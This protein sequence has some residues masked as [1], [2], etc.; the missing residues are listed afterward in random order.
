MSE[1]IAVIALLA[2]SACTSDPMPVD[3]G[4]D[5]GPALD[6]DAGGC[7]AGN[8]PCATGDTCCGDLV[9]RGNA[10]RT[11]CVAANDTCFVGPDPGCCFDPAD[12]GSGE[13][14]H[15][16]EC[17]GMGEGVCKADPPAGS[18]WSAIDC[19][20]GGPCVGAQVCGCGESCLVPDV[21]GTC[22]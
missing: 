17:R 22:M 13:R 21:L 12:C 7:V 5:G 3:A 16:A 18:C 9:C 20:G 15:N 10:D 19:S 8:D 6:P 11:F 14:C 4:I 1:K 2:L